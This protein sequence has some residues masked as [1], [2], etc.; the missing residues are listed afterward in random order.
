[1]IHRASNA[2]SRLT[3]TQKKKLHCKQLRCVVAFYLVSMLLLKCV[4]DLIIPTLFSFILD[5]SQIILE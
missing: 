4:D 3:L 5:Y 2:L 1:M